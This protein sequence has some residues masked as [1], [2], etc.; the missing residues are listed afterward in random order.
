[1]NLLEIANVLKNDYGVTH[2]LNLDGGG[3]T[4]LVMADPT[5]HVVNRPSDGTERFNGNNFGVFARAWPQ[6]AVDA[7]GNWSTAA[8]WSDGVPN[9]I[10]HVAHLRDTISA[11]RTITLSAGVFLGTLNI[12]SPRTYTIAGSQLLT[13]DTS[14]GNAAVNVNNATGSQ[15]ISA[16]LQLNDATDITIATG[17]SLALSGAINNG[18]SKTINKTGGGT[19]TISGP[20]AH[21]AG[22]VINVNAGTLA[23]VSNTGGETAANVTLNAN[24]GTTRLESKQNLQSLNIA[25]AGNVT[26][27]QGGQRTLKTKSLTIAGAGKLDATDNNLVID[28]TGATSPLGSAS[29][30]VYSGVTRMIQIGRGVGGT[31]TGPGINSSRAAANNGLTALAIAEA[32]VVLHLTAAQ[33]ATWHGQN[34]DDTS[35][36][37]MYTYDGDANLDGVIDA[38]DYGRIDNFVQLPGAFGYFNGDFNYD[39]IIDA[40]DYGIIDNNIQLQGPPIASAPGAASASLAAVPEPATLAMITSFAVALSCRRRRTFTASA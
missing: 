26:I 5:R 14:V 13:L 22:A 23:L 40:G 10:G 3:S 24:G 15:V 31:W 25:A 6:W 4:T 37:V 29:G 39:G 12:D 19:L 7:S 20:Q 21:S 16:P 11:N 36:L 1:M 30:G 33:T 8:N 18:S 2:A 27:P 17:G 34:V 35:V 38:A 9:G 28:Y 32:A